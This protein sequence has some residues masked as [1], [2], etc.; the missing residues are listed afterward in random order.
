MM[1]SD[2][3]WVTRIIPENVSSIISTR[4]WIDA[5][6]KKT[7]EPF[8]KIL[9]RNRSSDLHCITLFCIGEDKILWV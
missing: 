5:N 1:P 6:H 4:F 7:K 9:I 8:L 3:N 2:P